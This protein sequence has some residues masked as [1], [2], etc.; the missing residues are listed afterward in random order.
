MTLIF[1]SL[2]SN[3][4]RRDKFHRL[5]HTKQ[6]GCNDTSSGQRQK[7]CAFAHVVDQQFH[8]DTGDLPPMKFKPGHQGKEQEC[9]TQCIWNQ[10]MQLLLSGKELET[11]SLLEGYDEPPQWHDH[12]TKT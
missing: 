7:K 8:E 4:R 3:L 2:Q 6:K 11:K 5:Q 12:L 9:L 1:N 10:V